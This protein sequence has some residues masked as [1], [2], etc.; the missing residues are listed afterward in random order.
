MSQPAWTP[1]QVREMAGLMRRA[2]RG[3]RSLGGARGHRLWAL[4]EA[5]V[6][7]LAGHGIRG[8]AHTQATA[9]LAVRA[10]GLLYR[11]RGVSLRG[12]WDAIARGVPLR[13]R[14]EGLW[15]ITAGA[16]YA[17]LALGAGLLAAHSAAWAHVLL[18]GIVPGT[19]GQAAVTPGPALVIM[20]FFHNAVAT[21]VAYAG[22]ILLGLGALAALGFNASLVGAL[23]GT[24]AAHGP[25][26]PDAALLA[27]H[28]VLELPAT[29][30]AGGGGLAMGYAWLAPG[31]RSRTQALADAFR[32]TVPLFACAI[33]WLVGAALIEGL[34]TPLP[35]PAD[36]KLAAAGFLAVLFAVYLV[37][38]R[39][40]GGREKQAV[41]VLPATATPEPVPL[42]PV[43]VAGSAVRR[44]Q[45]QRANA[46]VSMRL[47]E[48]LQVE[49]QAAAVPSRALALLLD[50]VILTVGFGVL[51]LAFSL[52]FGALSLPWLEAVFAVYLAAFYG[53]YAFLFEW[54]GDGATPGKRAFGLMVLRTDG[55]P[56][57]GMTALARNVLRLVDFLPAFYAVGLAAALAS[58]GSR[59]LGDWAAGTVV[60]H[61]PGVRPA[62]RRR[63]GVPVPLPHVRAC[64]PLPDAARLGGIA[65]GWCHNLARRWGNGTAE[66]PE[67]RHLLELMAR[68]AHLSLPPAPA[69]IL[70][71]HW[72][73]ALDRA[74]YLGGVRWYSPDPR[75]RTEDLAPRA[76]SPASMDR[77]PDSLAAA[78]LNYWS[79]LPAITPARRGALAAVLAA[80]LAQALGALGL[81]QPDPDAL[82]EH[83]A[84]LLQQR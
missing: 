31:E 81:D 14:A 65:P 16:L 67:A 64:G 44:P 7:H 12:F 84:Y 22:G 47:P 79:R 4:Y 69:G 26:L 11:P 13:V 34:F 71:E 60:V 24:V 1:D 39:A 18:Q 2:R 74:G 76:P 20:L 72:L 66:A 41:P 55:R 5:A 51:L 23:L 58:G 27:P 50:M 38:P 49:L 36:A 30:V 37:L 56:L 40:E 83:A 32:R 73:A 25:L 45:P 9:A 78:V 54:L 53:L 21:G 77:V 35:I 42:H 63:A 19:S 59:R 17:A 57:D 80:R 46:T 15:V 52:S 33:A 82:V 8:G 61:L 28:A 29:F 68:T 48:G 6:T 75:P 70:A 3:L 10:F 62:S 43:M